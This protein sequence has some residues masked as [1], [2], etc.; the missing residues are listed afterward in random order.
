M[1]K[2]KIIFQ[3][4]KLNSILLLIDLFIIIG[5]LILYIHIKTGKSDVK[6]NTKTISEEANT[7]AEEYVQNSSSLIESYALILKGNTYYSDDKPFYFGYDNDYCG[8]F[9]EDNI[10][11]EDYLYSLEKEGTDIILKIYN[12]TGLDEIEYVIDIN[13]DGGFNLHLKSEPDK[14]IILKC[15]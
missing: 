12:R 10:N 4:N 7:K 3:N 15:R 6:D 5:M 13:E 14:V 2:I 1:D 8:Y 9:D 11:V